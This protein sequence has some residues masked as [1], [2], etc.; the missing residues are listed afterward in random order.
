M[1]GQHCDLKH[2]MHCKTRRYTYSTLGVLA[3]IVAAIVLILPRMAAAND[4]NPTSLNIQA[5]ELTGREWVNG[6]T[7]QPVKLSARHRQDGPAGERAS[8]REV[9]Q[10]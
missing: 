10:D 1:N 3:L 9:R 4:E 7:N 8:E 2:G 5:P 6:N